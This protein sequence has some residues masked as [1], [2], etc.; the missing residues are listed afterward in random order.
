MKVEQLFEANAK[1]SNTSEIY[2]TIRDYETVFVD[3]INPSRFSVDAKTGRLNY[4]GN[5]EFPKQLYVD[6]EGK[7]PFE[8]GEIIG[9]FV[10]MDGYTDKLKD[11][12][13]LPTRITGDLKIFSS[14]AQPAEVFRH[15]P[16]KLRRL[17]LKVPVIHDCDFGV[18]ECDNFS[19]DAVIFHSLK[20]SPRKVGYYIIDC[21]KDFLVT[22]EG[23]SPDIQT[24]ELWVEA[25]NHDNFDFGD[26]PFKA[27]KIGAIHVNAH[28]FKKD[29]PMLAFFRVKGLKTIVSNL[30][31]GN[32]DV[33]HILNHYLPDND[34]F[35]CQEDL[36]DS[37]R[38]KGFAK[39]K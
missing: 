7:L 36:L 38:L 8:F 20:G 15:F 9:D 13:G 30:M 31:G 32:T 14:T 1:L 28:T 27:Q 19:I 5:I 26:L 18:E 22:F 17:I 25:G 16:K 24:L 6:S 33:L 21:S 35:G 10:L 39:A 2:K 37:K 4:K 3:G 29:Y 12:S 23:I 11:L 34:V